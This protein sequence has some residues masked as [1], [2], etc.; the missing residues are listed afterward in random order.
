MVPLGGSPSGLEY[1]PAGSWRLGERCRAQPA[2][3]QSGPNF[4]GLPR[5]GDS[6]F[7]S[8][9]VASGGSKLFRADGSKNFPRHH[10]WAQPSARKRVLQHRSKTKLKT[11]FRWLMLPSQG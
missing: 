8:A 11:S 3:Q 10:G 9:A 2:T 1:A 4:V 5:S 6:C 7:P